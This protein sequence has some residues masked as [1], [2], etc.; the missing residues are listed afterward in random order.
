MSTVLSLHK[1]TKKFGKKAAVSNV[2]VQLQAG[3]IYGFLGPNGAGKTTTI[4]MILD[5][6]RP[7]SGS[8]SLFDNG[9]AK[10][11]V[12]SLK[13][14]GYLSADNTFYANWTAKRHFAYAER[15]RGMKTDALDL[16][17]RFELDVN[18]KYRHLS[19]GNKQKL[20]LILA[21]MHKPKLLIL[22]EPTR[23][24]DPL[25][26]ENIYDMLQDFKKAGG[27]VFMSSHNLGE[28]QKVCD[29]VG[30]IREGKLVASETM[31]SL[32]KMHVHEIRVLFEKA[33]DFKKFEASN[34]EVKKA[35]DLE[36]IA[37]VR[38]DFNTFLKEVTKYTLTD[39]DVT[40]VSLEDMFMRFYK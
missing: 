27:T 9:N 5:F 7:T 37:H 10:G 33:V 23:G 35:E 29:R 18:T 30:I 15:V 16:A 17:R 38:G 12:T 8:V 19:S 14:V 22:D 26:Q 13:D 39:L 21:M 6:I 2:S 24:L 28:V 40:H 34:V 31:Q 25:L 11:I 32:R 4:R 3:E 1:V 36:L 20:S